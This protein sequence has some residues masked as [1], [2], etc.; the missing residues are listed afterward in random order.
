ML[1]I[2]NAEFYSYCL[3]YL[4]IFRQM[5]KDDA[6][7]ILAKTRDKLHSGMPKFSISKSKIAFEASF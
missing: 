4:N 3:S 7:E 1:C 2:E 5:K 6:L